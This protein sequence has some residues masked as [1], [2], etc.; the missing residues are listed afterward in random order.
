MIMLHNYPFRF[1]F[2]DDLMVLVA[3]GCTAEQCEVADIDRIMQ[4]TLDRI[5][6]PQMM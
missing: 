4:N 1:I 3:D 5:I 6:A 2:V